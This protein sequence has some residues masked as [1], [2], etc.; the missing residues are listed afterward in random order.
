MILLTSCSSAQSKLRSLSCR[1]VAISDGD[2]FTCLLK[3]NKKMK[4]RLVEIDSP[5]RNQPF[6]RKSRQFLSELIYKREVMLFIKKYDR[7]QRA[8]ATVYDEQSRNINLMMVQQGMAWAYTR[9]IQNPHY[10]QAQQQAQQQRLGL[11]ND[12]HLIAPED[13]RR[14]YKLS[15]K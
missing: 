1:V 12:P 3:N 14:M 7:Y 8:L 13:W 4:V 11:W 10:L 9:Y 6:G 5:E 15:K 2:T